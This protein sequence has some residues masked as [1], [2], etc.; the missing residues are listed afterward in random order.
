[1]VCSHL[2][3]PI[4]PIWVVCSESHF[5]LLYGWDTRTARG[6]HMLP[7][8]AITL[9]YYDGLANQEQP[10]RLT[11]SVALQPNSIA[12]HD[13]TDYQQ[14]CSEDALVPPLEH[15]VHTKWPKAIVT[16][17]GSEPIL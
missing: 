7:E 1:M 13:Q 11:L 4:L 6:M 2:K 17:F 12:K 8:S 9:M 16:W 5:T 14:H 10:I 3:E 15:V